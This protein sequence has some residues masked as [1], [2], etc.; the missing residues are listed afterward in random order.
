MLYT[1][2]EVRLQVQYCA[3]GRRVD[4]LPLFHSIPWL[5][6]EGAFREFLR[7]RLSLGFDGS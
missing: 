3:K 6:V 1:T 4:A 7:R 2:Q 5:A